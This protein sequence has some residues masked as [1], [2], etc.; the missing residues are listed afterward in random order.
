MD[1]VAYGGA[2]APRGAIARRVESKPRSSMLARFVH[3]L[4]ETRRRQAGREITKYAHLMAPEWGWR[5]P[6]NQP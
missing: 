1:I 2:R 5:A 6:D 3:A 4:R